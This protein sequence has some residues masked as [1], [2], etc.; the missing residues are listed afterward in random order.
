MEAAISKHSHKVLL[1]VCLGKVGVDVIAS[2][3]Q[4]IVDSKKSFR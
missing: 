4:F 1:T 3:A 2:L